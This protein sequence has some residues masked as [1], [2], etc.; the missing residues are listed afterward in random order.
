MELRVVTY[1]EYFDGE[2]SILNNM[3][4]D[5]L[6]A[7]HIRK[8]KWTY[9]QILGLLEEIHEFYHEKIVFHQMH[10]MATDFGLGGVHLKS[11]EREQMNEAQ[12]LDWLDMWKERGCKV[13]T[14]IHNLEELEKYQEKFDLLI[15][16]PI[17]ESI[18]KPGYRSELDWLNILKGKDLS[19]IMAMGGI[20]ARNI[21]LIAPMKFHSCGAMGSIWKEGNP[22][23][24]YK[25]LKSLCEQHVHSS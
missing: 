10:Q 4:K 17:F 1:P 2:A 14:A 13:S 5:G 18:M 7:L 21:P 8:P 19:K 11:T 25:A 24:N 23:E 3:L 20:S 12:I 22:F 6:S 9:D 16:S 15:L